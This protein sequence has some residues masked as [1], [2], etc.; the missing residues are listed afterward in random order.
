M[1]GRRIGAR[2]ALRVFIEGD[3]LPPLNETQ[4]NSL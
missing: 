3:C 1:R 2:Q 4:A